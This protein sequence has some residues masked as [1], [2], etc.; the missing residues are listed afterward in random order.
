M[1]SGEQAAPARVA[2]W[3]VLVVMLASGVP[4]MLALTVVTPILPQIQDAMAGTPFEAVMVKNLA[5][6]VSLA[7]AAG[8]PLA[9]I[10]ADRIGRRS[11]MIGSIVI[12]S[13]A[14]CLAYFLESLYAMIATRLV[15]GVTAA[16]II[17]AGYA[18]IGDYFDGV[19]RGRLIGLQLTISTIAAIMLVPSVTA[20]AQ[21]SWRLAFLLHGVLLPFG[22]LA[23]V[24]LPKGAPSSDGAAA[25]ARARLGRPPV[26]LMA[27]ALCCGAI[28]MAPSIYIPFRLRQAG[29]TDPA[30]VALVLMSG[31]LT[32]ATAAA[33]YG[34]ARKYLSIRACFIFSF[35][36]VALALA[37]AA[38][39]R[40]VP[41][42]I[43]VEL[44]LGVGSGWIAP[45]LISAANASA[46]DA[47]RGRVVGLVKGA[48]LVA[49]FFA[50]LALEPISNAAG[51]HGVLLSVSG[52]SLVMVLVAT[53]AISQARTP[54]FYEAAPQS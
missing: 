35:S 21:T 51:P 4:A 16:A 54:R 40:A 43:A 36:C 10:L 14:G 44:V 24:A 12:F 38:Y 33:L 30:Q 49:A 42:M 8:A 41:T 29:I 50:I 17:T 11:L 22:L 18:L 27:L 26:G 46:T 52:L 31:P 7:M 13:L 28:V 39:T 5:G 45:N 23:A 3:R 9:G 2:D 1:G 34:H 53:L 32:L 48:N 47:N 20:L 6:A 19:R 15:V 37:A 25:Q